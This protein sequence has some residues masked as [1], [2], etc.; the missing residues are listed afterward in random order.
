MN[1]MDGNDPVSSSDRWAGL[2]WFVG[3]R[4]RDG[5]VDFGLCT[6]II[7][8]SDDHIVICQAVGETDGD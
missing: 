2:G 4:A 1:E 7:D 3:D 6:G 8:R 5:H